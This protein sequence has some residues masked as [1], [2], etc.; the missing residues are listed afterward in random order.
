MYVPI[1]QWDNPLL[2]NRGG[3]LGFH[4]IGRLKPGVTIDQ[5]RADMEEVTRNLAAAFPDADRGIGATLKPLKEQMVGEARPF[6]LVLLGAVGCVLLIA[7][8]NVAS[9]QLARSTARSR[10]F[11]VRAALGAGRGRI[12]RQLL[13]ESLLLGYAA[14]ALGLAAAVFGTRAAIAALP[15]ALPRGGEVGTDLRVLAFTF[16]LS[17]LTGILFGLV[18]AIETSRTDPQ[19]A[20]KRGGRGAMGANQRALGAFVVAEMAIALVLLA[21]AGLMIRS[22]ARLW[23]VDPGFDAK[24]VLDFGLSLPPE[25][26]SA[27]PEK[28]RAIYREVDRQ[29]SSVPGIESL[30]QTWAAI[31]MGSEDDM[32]FWREGVPRPQDDQ[33]MGWTLD[34]IVGAD[35][36]RVMRI[37][38]RSG[39]FFTAHDNDRSP[40]IAVVDEVFARKFFPGEDPLG[41]RLHVM[42]P[43]RTLEIVGVVGHVKQWGL[44]ADDAQPLRAQLYI[45]WMQMPDEYVLSTPTGTNLIVRYKGGL[46]EALSALRR[47]NHEMSNEQVIYRDTTMEAMIADSLASRRFAMIV[48]GAF[49]ALALLLAGIGIYGVMAYLVSQRTQEV[50]IRMALGAQR[51]H[52]LALVLRSGARLTLFGVVAG[53]AGAIALTRLMR[54]LLFDVSPTDPAILA[55]VCALLA[56][57]AM[58]ACILP[59]RKA[60]SIDPMRALRTE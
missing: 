40:L 44:D 29:F 26:N 60:A 47:K 42:N 5:A 38:V 21:G 11:A 39:R 35:Y 17:L 34:Y 57:V 43:E 20:L 25:I 16:V 13:T 41:K 36:L 46:S 2:M 54:S 33:H 7:C 28:I 9:L 14:G 24:G 56:A 23:S 15:A 37:P 30:S 27:S 31:P 18:P 51:G 19:T 32:T 12:L 48:L 49:A 1:R 8:V 4:G 53:V 55:G 58:A 45:P 52:V 3:G 50:G 6:L 59:A 22:L 10:E